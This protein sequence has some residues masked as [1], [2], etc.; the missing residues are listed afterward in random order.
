MDRQTYQRTSA[1]AHRKV[2]ELY[3]DSISVDLVRLNERAFHDGRRAHNHVAGQAGRFGLEEIERLVRS[4][5]RQNAQAVMMD[6]ARIERALTQK[7]DGNF[8]F[9]Q[10]FN[11]N[12]DASGR[13]LN[14]WKRFTL[15]DSGR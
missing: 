5:V 14:G 3:G 8:P 6:P 10:V 2:E 11:L 7:S 9:V 13:T 1:A 15:W 4:F 12:N